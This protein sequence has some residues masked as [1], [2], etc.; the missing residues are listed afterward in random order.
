MKKFLLMSLLAAGLLSG[1]GNKKAEVPG[2]FCIG[3]QLYSV[4][5]ELAKAFY[6]TL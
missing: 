6:G 4:R 5:T 2:H 3:F 1:C